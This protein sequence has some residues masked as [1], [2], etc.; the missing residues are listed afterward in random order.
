MR[1][2]LID[3]EQG[4]NEVI[5]NEDDARRTNALV[6]DRLQLK[7]GNASAT[8]IVDHSKTFV[9]PGEI[10]LFKEVAEA[11]QAGEGDE[12]EA[13]PAMRPASLNY[14][15][16]KL[17]GGILSDEEINA[18]ICDLMQQ[19]LS[20]TEL[21]SFVT[22]V[23]IKGLTTDET[24]SLTKAIIASG[25]TLTP[26]V[27]PAASEHS[28]GGVAGG[29][30]SM[31]VAPIMASL[32]VCFPKTASRAISS[33]CAT[34]DAM[35]I[36]APVTLNV[37]R[38]KQVLAQANACIV[39]GGGVNMAAADDKLIQIRNPLR[40]DPQPLLV[41]SILAKKKAEGAEY[42]VLDIPTGRGAK[43]ATIEQ[44]RDLA[45]AFE[46]FG[47][48]LD[49]KI[50]VSISDGSEP[51]LKTLGPAMEARAIVDILSSRGGNGD[52]ALLEKACQ[53]AGILLHMI[54][55]ITREEGYNISRHQ[56]ENGRAWQK[57]RE[58]IAAQGGDDNVTPQSI[59]VGD[60]RHTVFAASDGRVAHVDNKS[61]SIVMRAMGAPKEKLAGIAIHVQKGQR[62]IRGEALYDLVAST[63][64]YLQEGI[65]V[66]KKNAV[67]ELDRVVL[68]VV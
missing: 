60:Q 52:G 7:C 4:Q 2:K 16:K 46:L 24:A 53:Q 67:V 9:K 39:W 17:D 23:Y 55:G 21:A 28:I 62:I 20:G 19:K 49:L 44:A 36:L 3:I 18:I 66:A 63:R 58:I 32:G 42:V 61:V 12:V 29:R 11:L 40:L 64:E 27:R 10:G 15:R 26:P 35:E 1:A 68:D 38:I 33:A 6:G 51:L 14:I 57:M 48:A 34:A 56:V 13:S 8:A 45:R 37:E 43:V 5:I 22:A 31:L 50:K 41:S 59:A 25:E 54:R 30:S 65:E 47:T